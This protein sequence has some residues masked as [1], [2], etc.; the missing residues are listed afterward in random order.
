MKRCLTIAP[1]LWVAVA[2]TAQ[3]NTPNDGDWNLAALTLKNT[4]EADIM[5]RV[6]DIDNLGFGWPEEFNPF[7]GRATPSHA[8]PWTPAATDPSGT[9]R[10]MMPSKYKYGSHRECDGYC[11]STSRPGNNPQTITIPLDDVKGANIQTAALQLFID[12]F[13]APSMNSKFQFKLNGSRFVEAEKIVNYIDQTGPIGK[14]ITIKLT[15]ELLALLQGNTLTI[16]IDDPTTG[17]GDGYAVDF[18]KLLINP[19]II[20]RG[21]ISGQVIDMN[22]RKPITGAT[23]QVPEYGSATTDGEGNFK[24][25]NMPAGLNIVTASAAGYASGG[26]QADVIADENT[27]EPLLIE[28]KPSGKVN[29]N[30]K[31]LREGDNLVL[32]NVQ[33]D[34]NSAALLPAGKTELDKLAALMKQNMDMEILLEGHTSSEGQAAANRQ[35]SLRRVKSCKDYLAGKGIDEGRIGVRGYGPDM[36]V[37]DNNTEAGRI[38]NRRVELKVTKL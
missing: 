3:R 12:D 8:Y 4:A 25:E 17:V 21:S 23:V 30:N 36:P 2:V 6:G 10:I 14:L 38:K 34:V 28:L 27:Q 35:L 20:Y 7:T 9:D 1:L 22:T 19:K 5:I 24:L 18:V 31:A 37:A 16:A 33:F 15:D 11:G 29:F 13:Q 26:K 32:N